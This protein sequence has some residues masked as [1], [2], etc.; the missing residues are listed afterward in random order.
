MFPVVSQA[1]SRYSLAMLGLL[2][3]QVESLGLDWSQKSRQLQRV[4][5]INTL[6]FVQG[7]IQIEDDG[8]DMRYQ[9]IR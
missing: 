6:V 8:V 1:Y 4:V 3:V 9:P 5:I 2:P 7:A